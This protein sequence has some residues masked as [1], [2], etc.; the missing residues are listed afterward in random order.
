MPRKSIIIAQ[1]GVVSLPPFAPSTATLDDCIRKRRS[2]RSFSEEPL[3]LHQIAPVLWAAQGITGLGGLRTAPSAG[4][5]HPLR[6]Y[7]AAANVIGLDAGTYRYDPDEHKLVLEHPDEVRDQLMAAA[8]DQAAVGEAPA[9]IVLTANFKR[10]V[11]EFGERGRSLAY[12][13][14]GHA[15]QNICLKATALSLG[16]IGMGVFDAAELKHLLALPAVDDPVYLIAFGHK[17]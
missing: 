8:N 2:C 7:V 12:M 11:R 15:G 9:M 14:A 16:V 13:E 4:A 3:A 6:A 5:L 10:M 17:L 1:P